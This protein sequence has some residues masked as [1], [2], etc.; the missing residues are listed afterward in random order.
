MGTKKQL[1]HS[2]DEARPVDKILQE[3]EAKARVL[4]DL[5]F[6]GIT[7][8][9]NGIVLEVNKV[10]LRLM[11]YK[12]LDEFAHL[13]VLDLMAPE[14]RAEV[15]E[16]MEAGFEGSYEVTMQR[17]DDSNFSA[18]LATKNIIYM[19][20]PAQA[21]FVRDL[22]KRKQAEEAL[23]KSEEQYRHLVEQLNEGI[24]VINYAGDVTFANPGMARMLGYEIETLKS[25]SYFSFMDNLDADMVKEKLKQ[26]HQGISDLYEIGM[27][28][29][30]G[31]QIIVSV[32]ASPLRD[33]SGNVVGSFAVIS[34]IS[35]RKRAEEALAL[36]KEAAEAANRAKSQFLANVSHEIRTPMSAVIG[37]AQML[38]SSNLNDEQRDY[39]SMINDSAESLLSIIN[40]VLD[41]SKIEAVKMPIEN[42]EFDLR[43]LLDEVMDLMSIEAAEKGLAIN[44]FIVPRVPTSVSGDP[45]RLRQVLLNLINNAVKFTE[46]G[47][48]VLSINIE[49][50]DG[51]ELCLRFDIIDTGIGMS[52]ATRNHLFGKFMQADASTTR[53][54]GGTGLGLAISKSLVELMGGEIGCES[55]EGRGSTFWFTF[56]T[57]SRSGHE[58]GQAA[59]AQEASAIITRPTGEEESNPVLV[60]EDTPDLQRLIR[61]QLRKLGL[62]AEIAADGVQAVHQFVTHEYAAIL[63]DCHMP[64]MDGYQ[65]TAIIRDLEKERGGHIP[66]IALTANALTG[67]RQQ[68][69]DAGMDDYLAKPIRLEQL[70]EVLQNWLPRKGQSSAQ[71]I[72]TGS[73]TCVARASTEPAASETHR[74]NPYSVDI[75]CLRKYLNL[76]SEDEDSRTS[77]RSII[78]DYIATGD[79]RTNKLKKALAIDDAPSV[80]EI[81]H[82]F[83]ASSAYMGADALK[84]LLQ[85]LEKLTAIHDLMRM[86]LVLTAI[87]K[88]FAKVKSELQPFLA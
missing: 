61:A 88:E 75:N 18:E 82:S 36:A 64:V 63:M 23:R 20:A 9:R 4:A 83:K 19:G 81:A 26:R 42:I 41:L 71:S 55:Q 65:A 16:R 60:V 25:R 39:V 21:A 80:V 49:R 56:P 43:K 8:H 2:E 5:T 22:T 85:E 7:I 84:E 45:L 52:P 34:D 27:N 66:I 17:Q 6:D 46:R 3:S 73:P 40:D 33:D 58:T 28:R 74:V 51:D 77:M 14:S 67:E 70:M 86:R 79:E 57:R 38:F 13:N 12:S 87:E 32:S 44:E 69:L 10:F 68:C 62:M 1:R 72:I 30:D 47:A 37:A 35:E 31:E 15:Q 78:S 48:I 24:L 54:F 59:Q 50:E 76:D 11:G 53:R 29:L